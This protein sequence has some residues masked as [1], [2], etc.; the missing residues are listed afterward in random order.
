M[1]IG[2]LKL[3]ISNNWSELSLAPMI[4]DDKTEYEISWLQN[5]LKTSVQTLKVIWLGYKNTK[6]KFK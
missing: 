4:I 5:Q 2:K 6:D 1:V 3:A